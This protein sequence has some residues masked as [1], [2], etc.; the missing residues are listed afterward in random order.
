MRGVTGVNV[1]PSTGWTNAF[2]QI[3]NS[4]IGQVHQAATGIWCQDWAFQV[5][6]NIMVVDEDID[7]FDLNQIMWA[8]ATRVYPPRDLV[9]FP[10][11]ANVTDPAV[12]PKDRIGLKGQTTYMGVRLLIDATKFLGNPRHE[13]YGGEKFAPVARVEEETMK[14]VR[15]RWAE[16]G[17]K[18]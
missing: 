9:Q 11:S 7:I 5:A 2:I 12:H 15:D 4:Y 17:I 6:K 1:D 16:Y 3:D 8:L 10:G 18:L 13:D 14:R